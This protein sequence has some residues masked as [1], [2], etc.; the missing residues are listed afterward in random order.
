M[1][2][3][4]VACQNILGSRFDQ[5]VSQEMLA[6]PDIPGLRHCGEGVLSVRLKVS[7]LAFLKLVNVRL[8]ELNLTWSH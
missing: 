5:S 4:D 8:S 2:L 3:V 7:Q 6:N 1:Y